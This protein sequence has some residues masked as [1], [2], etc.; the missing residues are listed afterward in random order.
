MASLNHNQHLFLITLFIS[1]FANVISTNVVTKSTLLQPLSCSGKIQTCKSNLYHISKGLQVEQI[2]SFYSVNTSEIKPI[3]HGTKQDYLVSVPCTCKNINGTQGYF[4]DTLYKVESGDSYAYVVRHFYSGQ[5]WKIGGEDEPFV[6]GNL[7]TM[8]LLCGCVEI[9]S[10][11]VVTYTVQEHDTLSQIAQLLSA[12]WIE[13][14]GLNEV[15]T[16]NPSFIDVGWVLFVPMEIRRI[17][18]QK[19]GTIL[20]AFKS[21]K[22][23]LNEKI[24]ACTCL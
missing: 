11:K 22:L 21:Y 3:I 1:V 16:Q 8:H 15:L 12:N 9:E 6:A 2:A 5:A 20:F 7:T 18:V 13:I 10:Q 4:Y 17:Q 24:P 14:E 19:Q 23:S